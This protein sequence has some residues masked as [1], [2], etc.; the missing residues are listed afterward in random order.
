MFVK[1]LHESDLVKRGFIGSNITNLHPE[2]FV[3]TQFNEKSGIS[4]LMTVWVDSNIYYYIICT[5]NE[6]T[7]DRGQFTRE[8]QLDK[9]LEKFFNND[10]VS[11]MER[12]HKKT[13]NKLEK[14]ILNKKMKK[15][16]LGFYDISTKFEQQYE[17]NHDNS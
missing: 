4:T 6:S 2:S 16:N 1:Y 3:K 10:Y 5:A 12:K 9:I 15:K 7:V 14:S 8:E 13:Y 11:Y 17:V